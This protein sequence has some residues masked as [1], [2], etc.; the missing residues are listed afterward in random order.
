MTDD[1]LLR[2]IKNELRKRMRGLRNA[3]PEAAC[4]ARSA[5][6]TTRLE[7][8]DCVQSARSVAIFRAITA[9]HE[10][11]LEAFGASLSGR[12][13]KVAY[14]AIDPETREMTFR[15]AA[16]ADLEDRGFGFAEPGPDAP[17]ANGLDVVVVPALAV[18][19]SGHRLGYGAGFYD[20]TLPR[21]CPPAVAV[22][23]AYDYQLLAEVPVTDGDFATSWIVT[24]ARALQAE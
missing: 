14:P 18:A 22:T 21:F 12:G 1:A 8:L 20:R 6:I 13:V 9:R 15:F 16:A 24:D 5:A 11:D 4:A 3:A 2:R 19:P 17:L 23:V 7:A 10:V